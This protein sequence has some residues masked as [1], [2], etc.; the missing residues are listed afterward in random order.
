M[1][2]GGKKNRTNGKLQQKDRRKCNHITNTGQKKAGGTY[3]QS[4]FKEETSPE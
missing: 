2:K 1:E 3:Q 4:D